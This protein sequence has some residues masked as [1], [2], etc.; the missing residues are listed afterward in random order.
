MAINLLQAIGYLEPR[1]STDLV[2]AAVEVLK[3]HEGQPVDGFLDEIVEELK[4]ALGTTIGGWDWVC[5]HE[6]HTL[7]FNPTTG[8]RTRPRLEGKRLVDVL[9]PSVVAKLLNVAAE[10]LRERV[11]KDRGVLRDAKKIA[12]K[13]VLQAV[14]S[15]GFWE[16]KY[17]YVQRGCYLYDSE[18]GEWHCP[19]TD[20]DVIGPI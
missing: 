3:P 20:C 1:L 6:P 10:V 9:A 4:A 17:S 12:E 18:T 8:E 19:C 13:A 15:L 14:F 7:W 5:V 11:T 2:K 16:C